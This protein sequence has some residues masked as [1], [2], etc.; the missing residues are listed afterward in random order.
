MGETSLMANWRVAALWAVILT[1]SGWGSCSA[2]NQ[3]HHVAASLIAAQSAAAPGKPLTVALRERIEP[4]WHTYWTNPGDSGEAT[5][6]EWALP[7]GA[8]AGPIQ[9][10]LPHTIPVGPLMEY[11]YDDEVLLLS[12]I[13]VPANAS[14][15]FKIA[16]KVSYLVCKDICIP[17]DTHV[18]LTLP[19]AGEAAP[20]DAAGVIA[21]ARAALPKPLPGAVSYAVNPAKGALRLTVPADAVLFA[22]MTEARFYPLTWGVVSNP[23]ASWR[24]FRAAN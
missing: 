19:V 6:I 23:R 24:S 13:E 14:G 4:G 10:A 2:A 22:G 8:K 12:E 7:E 5:S 11:G 15:S 1:A 21:K 20:S 16:A 9:W 17:E 3:P 18:E